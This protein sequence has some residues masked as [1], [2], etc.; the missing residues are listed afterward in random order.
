MLS[1]A[2]LACVDGEITSLSHSQPLCPLGISHNTEGALR[3]LGVSRS[4]LFVVPLKLRDK[5]PPNSCTAWKGE[6]AF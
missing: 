6:S 5:P 3:E 2:V 4:P 1:S